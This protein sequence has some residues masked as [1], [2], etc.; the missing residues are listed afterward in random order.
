MTCQHCHRTL[1]ASDRLRRGRCQSCYRYWLKTGHD[2]PRTRMIRRPGDPRPIC[3]RCGR[4]TG[5]LADQSADLCNACYQYKRDHGRDRPEHLWRECCKICRRPRES[6]KFA[7]GRC[8]ICANYFNR[9]GRERTP[10]MVAKQAPHGWCYC[11][12]PAV[13]TVTVWTRPMGSYKP[14][15]EPLPLCAD[16]H[17]A[18]VE[19][20]R[21]A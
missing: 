11:G 9:Y 21:Y 13:T 15:P 3:A 8:V 4:W 20:K 6:T 17:A 12:Q 5:R 18:E 10:E 16:C 7:K 14:R 19:M 2:R 1:S